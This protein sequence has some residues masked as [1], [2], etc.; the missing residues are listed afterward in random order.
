MGVG[1][2]DEPTWYV[3]LR[4]QGSF[5][6]GL[7]ALAAGGL[8]YWAGLIQARAVRETA[9]ETIDRRRHAFAWAM[10]GAARYVAAVAASN[11]R[12]SHKLYDRLAAPGLLHS[13]WDTMSLLE[14][15]TQQKVASLAAAIELF[16]SIVGTAGR[17]NRGEALDTLRAI[18]EEAEGLRTMLTE[19]TTRIRPNFERAADDAPGLLEDG[20]C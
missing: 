20:Y 17:P 12:D 15:P 8:A 2:P 5:L 9:R 10:A 18:E 14:I 7:F 4:D 19:F 3:L 1:L 11:A 6:G 13:D 16:N